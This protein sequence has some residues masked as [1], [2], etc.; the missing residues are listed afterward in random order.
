MTRRIREQR[1][2]A[3]EVGIIAAAIVAA[4]IREAS[5]RR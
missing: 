1:G 2:M 3:A 5:A 4:A